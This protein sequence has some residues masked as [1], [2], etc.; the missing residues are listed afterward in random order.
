M[1]W[2]HKDL[3][4]VLFYMVAVFNVL[5][6]SFA[7]FFTSLLDLEQKG[8]ASQVVWGQWRRKRVVVLDTLHADVLTVAAVVNVQSA[9]WAVEHVCLRADTLQVI[10]P[11]F[12]FPCS[13][14]ATW[15]H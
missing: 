5:K 2:V 1:I 11:D 7:Q 6:L 14:G 13:H 8:I 15:I 4:T 10:Q 12:S 9:M 3:K